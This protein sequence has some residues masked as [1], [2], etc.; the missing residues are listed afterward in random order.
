V[1][2]AEGR[3]FSDL[4][5]LVSHERSGSHYLGSYI[6]SLPKQTMVDE[7]CNEQALDPVRDPLSFFGFRHRRSIEVPDYSLRRTPHV[8]SKLLDEYF[9]FALNSSPAGG[10]TIDVKYGHIH[11]FEAAWWPIF[12]KPFL[13]EYAGSRGIKVVHLCRWNSLEAV[14]SGDVAESRKVWHA[15]G[16]QKP[17]GPADAVEV[18][19]KQLVHQIH[20]LNEQ[21]AAIFRWTKNLRCLAVLYEELVD[22]VQG[23]TC[24]DRVAEFL[25]SVPL[26]EFSS[27]YRKVTPPMHLAIRNWADVSTFCRDNEL[28]HY[29]LRMPR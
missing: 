7:V 3:D 20:M 21:K 15:V 14:I 25:G 12:R 13:F 5:L 8:V 1:S 10:V 23:R 2:D 6:R 27:P 4:A 22:P 26:R 24:R 17:A 18:D 28:A 19:T 11:N 16:A 29:L 9:S